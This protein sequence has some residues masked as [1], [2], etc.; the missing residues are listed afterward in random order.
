MKVIAWIVAGSL[1]LVQKANAQSAPNYES[2]KGW[3]LK[4]GQK[5]KLMGIGLDK[6]YTLLKNKKNTPIIVAVIDSGIDTLHEDLKP[7]LWINTKEIPNNGKDDDNNGYVDD[8]HGW[9]FLGGKDGTNIEKA[10]SEKARVYHA[11]K[12]LYSG[13]NIDTNRLSSDEKY[14]YRMWQKAAADIEP[15]EESQQQFSMLVRIYAK[16]SELDSTLGVHLHKKEFSTAEVE[17][18]IL[19]NDAAKKA[20]MSYVNLMGMLPLDKETK[21]T[22]ILQNLKEELDKMKDENEAKEVTPENL[23]AL[24]T[25]DN[26]NDINDRFYGNNDIMGKSSMHGTHVSGIIAA[27]RNNG[28]GID[29]I[30]D[31]VQIMTIRAVPNGD[32]YDKDIALAIKYAVDNGAKVI[33]MSFGKSFSP[34]KKWVDD[35]F[36]YAAKKDVLLIHAAGNDHKNIDSTDNF[37]STTFLNG[38][39]AT[40]VITVGASSDNS[41]AQ[42]YVASFSNYGKEGVDVFAPGNQ[43][44]STLPGGN[45]YGFLDGT[46]MASPVVAGVAALIRSYYPKLSATQVKQCI[47]QAATRCDTSYTVFKPGTKEKTTLNE[48][49]KTGGLLNAY[50]AVAAA[51]LLEK[52]QSKAP[53]I[54]LRKTAKTSFQ[55]LSTKQ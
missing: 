30:A 23:R 7:I 37:P 41:I 17:A 14:Q 42:N 12:K 49:C 29:G 15:S 25:K 20:K 47:E 18:A 9:N 11:Y 40:N 26:Y 46:S 51:D 8:V 35:A 53:V 55:P 22:F 34:E 36:A 1:L 33:N 31:N 39:K 45:A 3:H 28:K 48:L 43:I 16:L 4:D 32:E 6:T 10:A 5:D 13:K 2:L 50:N 27:A 44:Y 54:K 21:N 52:K 38:S 24:I 19:D